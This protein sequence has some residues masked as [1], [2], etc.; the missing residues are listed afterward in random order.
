[1]KWLI[2]SFFLLFVV[3][4][5]TKAFSKPLTIAVIDTG[6]DKTSVSK[7]CKSGHKSFTDNSPLQD[8]HGHGTHVAGVI[9]QNAGSTNY[10]IIS[11]K[12]Y[13]DTN[14]GSVNL[15]NTI[16][17][18]NYAVDMKVDFINYS[19]GGP[20]FSENEF[21]AI[22][23]ALN[24]NIKF[25]AAAGNEN[26]D[27]DAFCDYYPACYDKR[28]VSVGN[29]MVNPLL[30]LAKDS[31]YVGLFKELT[32]EN[33]VYVRSSFSNYGKRVSRWEVGT[34]VLSTLPGGKI[35]RMT[36]TSQAAGVATGKL[37]KERLTNE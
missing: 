33:R 18:I 27:L 7:L 9:E 17:A 35:G 14:P 31:A 29:L 26:S 6:I 12:Y 8:R 28:I 4:L 2:A 25:V 24:S 34:D 32:S 21:L 30:K 1:M 19:G 3:C 37:V 15:K 22:K 11:L 5:P 16:A 20:E 13:S 36:G 23:R 10:C